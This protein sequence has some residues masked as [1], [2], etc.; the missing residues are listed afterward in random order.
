MT[1]TG[2]PP[3]APS[4]V[5]D[6]GARQPD[7]D[8]SGRLAESVPCRGCGYD[9]KGL[10]PDGMCPECSTE[11]DRSIRGDMLRFSDPPWLARLARGVRLV[12]WMLVVATIVQV[13]TPFVVAFV[14][15]FAAGGGGTWA[16]TVGMAMAV[17]GIVAAGCALVMV[18]G[19]WLATSPEAGR[20]GS[21]RA[22]SARRLAR[23]CCL[24]QVVAAPL[25]AGGGPMGFGGGGLGGM[26][27]QPTPALQVLALLTI[28][29]SLLAVVG[30][31][32]GL[33]YLRGLA[34]RIPRPA[35]VWQTKATIWGYAGGQVLASVYAVWV[36]IALPTILAGATGGTG[37][38][39]AMMVVFGIGG[40]AVFLLTLVFGV[41]ALV[42][43]F[44]F[45]TAFGG[46]ARAAH[47]A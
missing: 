21:E 12:A 44:I 1:E 26:A 25:H 34:R 13:L 18:C 5:V 8:E 40:C 29:L 22:L 32:A 16:S 4:S 31:V 24:A 38:P 3:T 14:S 10:R 33:V 45:G 43:L 7:L 28:A 41:W 35:L 30:H 37:P 17:S 6:G 47:A 11:V 46:L 15:S 9:L 19:V 2:S 20:V 36:I 23:W 27:P 39:A 42:L